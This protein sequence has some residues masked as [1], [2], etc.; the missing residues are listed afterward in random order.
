MDTL[1]KKDGTTLGRINMLLT[2]H[3]PEAVSYVVE[4][5]KLEPAWTEHAKNGRTLLMAVCEGGNLEAA[6]YLI[7][8][9]RYDIHAQTPYTSAEMTMFGK[10]RSSEGK[11]TPLFFAVKGGNPE[12]IRYLKSKGADVNGRTH[13]GVTPL[14]YAVMHNQPAVAVA[15]IELGADVNASISAAS[16]GSVSTT[17]LSSQNLSIGQTAYSLAREQRNTPMME[18]LKKAG[19]RPN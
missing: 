13:F 16:S 10:S 2:S 1:P 14:M 19:A 11:L 9:K 5:Y 12:L 6:K 8:E 7:E 15:L 18:L 3:N 17:E 4:R